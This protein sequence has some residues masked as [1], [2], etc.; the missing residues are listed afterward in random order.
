VEESGV[1]MQSE[2]FNSCSLRKSNADKF[3]CAINTM[4]N[5][6]ADSP[7]Q[8]FQEGS[9]K[10]GK[11]CRFAHSKAATPVATSAKRTPSSQPSQPAAKKAHQ[12]K[13]KPVEVSYSIEMLIDTISQ[14]PSPIVTHF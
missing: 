1:E 9:C 13:K 2:L 6:Y 7:C 4:S 8:F 11:R 10:R 12:E 5:P 14:F 3:T